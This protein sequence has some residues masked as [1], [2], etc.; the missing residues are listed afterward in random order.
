MDHYG[1]GVQETKQTTL[2]GLYFSLMQDGFT[3]QHLILI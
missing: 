2:D 3:S 1:M